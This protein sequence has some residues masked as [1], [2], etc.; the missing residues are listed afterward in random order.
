MKSKTLLCIFVLVLGITACNPTRHQMPVTTSSKEARELFWQAL[1]LIE[2]SETIKADKYL[3]QAIDLDPDF[4]LA[5]L[6]LNFEAGVT[7]AMQFVDKVSH[8]ESLM[9]RAKEAWVRKDFLLCDKI[10]NTLVN[11]LPKDKHIFY[12]AGRLSNFKNPEKAIEYYKKAIELDPHHPPPHNQLG[13]QLMKLKRY[14]EAEDAFYRYLD[15]HP[16]SGNATD[17]YA[18]LQLR[19]GEEEEAIKYYKRVLF[20]E[21]SFSYVYVKLAWI[22]IHQGNFQEAKKNINRLFELE[23]RPDDRKMAHSMFANIQFIQGN[24]SGALDILDQ[25]IE[26][27][28]KENNPGEAIRGIHFK[29]WYAM[30]GDMPELAL[31]T[32]TM[33]LNMIY[34]S[35]EE[36]EFKLS[37]TL[38]LYGSLSVLYGA[39]GDKVKAKQHLEEARMINN[40]SDLDQIDRRFYCAC[41]AAYNI[42]EGN[43]EQAIKDAKL[44]ADLASVP[45]K[46]YMALA[47]DLSGNREQ[48]IKYYDM[49]YKNI[50]PYYT[51]FFFNKSKNRL[52]E[53]SEQDARRK[54]QE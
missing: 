51:G 19:K 32:F 47:Y 13:Y 7:R 34:G 24:L 14:E 2:N 22:Y 20:L 1:E 43:Y 37:L 6:S 54:T 39:M 48:A 45:C 42:Y 28:I 27:Y 10:L 23:M 12:Y 15:M 31:E 36:L 26:S 50:N 16:E 52:E 40:N 8:A 11:L 29:G 53:L 49:A 35:A 41:S 17:S 18:E 21:P 30:H 9:I 5:H 38:G 44:F 4:A 33:G 46:Y 3:K 25:L